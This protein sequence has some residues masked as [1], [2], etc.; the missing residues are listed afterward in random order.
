MEVLMK[1]ST[2]NYQ[3]GSFSAD[4]MRLVQQKA[5]DNS[6]TKI[7]TKKD[8]NVGRNLW[9]QDRGAIS[10]AKE[11]METFGT[12]K[13]F[14]KGSIGTDFVK[15]SGNMVIEAGI[16]NTI[17]IG[18]DLTQNNAMKPLTD[19]YDSVNALDNWKKN[20]ATEK[21]DIVGDFKS[22]P[23]E[24]MQQNMNQWASNIVDTQA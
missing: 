18:K 23:Q 7:F 16:T 15:E 6:V 3:Q 22:S 8:L 20:N 10:A 13:V 2:S 17:Q 9:Q 21:R 11:T 19:I 4:T 12:D 14:K 24:R 1:I 5:S